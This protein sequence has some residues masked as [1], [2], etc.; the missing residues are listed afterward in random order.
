MGKTLSIEKLKLGEEVEFETFYKQYFALF[1]SFAFKFLPDKENCR[2]IVQETFIQYWKRRETFNDFIAIKVFFYRAIRNECINQLNRSKVHDKFVHRLAQKTQDEYFLDNIIREEVA[3][4]I[5]QKIEKLSP[6]EQRVLLM[7][8]D[9]MSNDEIARELTVS[10]N[11]V[12]T[13]KARAYQI[14]RENLQELRTI[15]MLLGSI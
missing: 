2:D 7:A 9:G 6:M 8:M 14:L 4:T 15:I 3:Y 13:H 11:T 5:H 10:L 1:L 12:K